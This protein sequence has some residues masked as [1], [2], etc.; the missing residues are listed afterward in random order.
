[1]NKQLTALMIAGSLLMPISVMADETEDL[2]IRVMEMNEN[3]VEAVTRNI[4]LPD[5][6][7][8]NA[9]EALQATSQNR[10]RN[11]EMI[12]DGGDQLMT[13][14]Q[15]RL[16][17]RL[18]EQEQDRVQMRENDREQIERHEQIHDPANFVPGM[19]PNTVL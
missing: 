13:Q 14:E 7:S 15:E 1:M 9:A 10:V 3:S 4:E 11:R 2:T 12:E 16:R 6:A 19:G 18:E 5:A 17:E 8:E